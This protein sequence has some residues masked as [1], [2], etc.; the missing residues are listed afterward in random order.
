[1][2]TPGPIP[3]RTIAA[4]DVPPATAL[5]TYLRPGVFVD[6]YTSTIP[7]TISQAGF[8]AAFYTTR[9]F[10]L[11]RF[12]LATFAASPSTDADAAQLAEGRT[13][14]FAAWTVEQRSEREILLAAGPTRSWLMAETVDRG[15][16]P[17]TT[18]YFGSA[19]VPTSRDRDG[20]P[21]MGWPFHALLGFHKLYSRL[22]L[23]AA[24][25]RLERRQT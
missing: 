5:A 9:L 22:L 11:E 2:N 21:V 16:T 15:G 14:R 19:V 3:G 8:I 20:R 13:D 25:R 24:V 4:S 1:M 12:L 10:K 7:G 17:A 23:G 18:L 6:C